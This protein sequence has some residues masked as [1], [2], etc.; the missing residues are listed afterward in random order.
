MPPATANRSGVNGNPTI[1]SRSL[2]GFVARA[3]FPTTAGGD[4]DLLGAFGRP[5][6]SAVRRWNAP[7]P[8]GRGGRVSRHR[9]G[10]AVTEV[11]TIDRAEHRK[12]S[13]TDDLDA[14]QHE[15]RGR[16]EHDRVL[17]GRAGVAVIAAESSDR[18]AT[19]WRRE[20]R[21]R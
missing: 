18:V 8:T 7:G 21:W 10:I 20:V 14:E 9:G 13:K 3:R 6:S 2:G 4:R 19:R 5:A 16:P 1:R 17:V 15:G 11:N 12:H